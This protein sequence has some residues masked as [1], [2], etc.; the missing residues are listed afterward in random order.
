MRE[1]T[2]A[3]ARGYPTEASK[4]STPKFARILSHSERVHSTKTT[5][6]QV[7]KLFGLIAPK[8]PHES[9]SRSS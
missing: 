4:Y 3:S 2:L 6:A 7:C 9:A 5:L 8:L 1:G